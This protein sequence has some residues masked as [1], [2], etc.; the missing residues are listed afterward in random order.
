[1]LVHAPIACWLL[2]PF[3]DLIAATLATDFFWQV[4][5]FLSAIGVFAGMLAATAGAMDFARADAA[6]PAIARWHAALMGAALALSAASTLGR[7][8]PDFLALTP[9]PAWAIGASALAL[10]GMIGG[11]WCGGELVYGRGIGVREPK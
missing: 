2:I 6:A 11:A 3:C 1:M 8:G 4:A 5:H 10:L 7:A 9:P